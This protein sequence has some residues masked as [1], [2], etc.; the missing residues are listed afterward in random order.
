MSERS[1]R[2]EFGVRCYTPT[3]LHRALLEAAVFYELVRDSGW[4]VFGLVVACLQVVARSE[5]RLAMRGRGAGQAVTAGGPARQLLPA[6]VVGEGV[7]DSDV[8]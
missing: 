4:G 3:M 6:F 1:P 7:F 2:D 5:A 8:V